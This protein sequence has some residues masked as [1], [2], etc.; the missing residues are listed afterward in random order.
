M[1]SVMSA[2]RVWRSL[3]LVGGSEGIR[4]GVSGTFIRVGG[5]S[6]AVVQARYFARDP[7]DGHRGR[8]P[9]PPRQGWAWVG[10]VEETLE[11]AKRHAKKTTSKL[12]YPLNCPIARAKK[13]EAK[14]I[15]GHR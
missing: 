6:S 3:T 12:H 9:T 2:A 11:R 13:E 7:E 15:K 10:M 14:K 1:T 5:S 8:P 4:H